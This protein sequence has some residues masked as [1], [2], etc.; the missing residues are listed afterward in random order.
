MI[1][2]CKYIIGLGLI[3]FITLTFFQG[4]AWAAEPSKV[5]ML[6]EI[7][8]HG[9]SVSIS[10]PPPS[11][12]IL[13]G[14]DL[15]DEY[16]DKPLFIMEKI[17]GVAVR[18]YGQ[19]AVASQFTMRGLR[20]GHNTGAAIFVDGVPL[21]E[22]TSHGDGYADLNLVIPED[23]DYIEVIKGPS[24]ALYG[25]FARAGVVN[26]ITKHRGNF[27]FYKFG[28]GNWGRKRFA[29]STGHEEG[30]RSTI[31][32][33]ELSRSEGATE[34][35]EWLKGNATGKFT[36]DFNDDIT[37]SIAMNFYATEWDHPEY[38]TEDQ[39]NAGDY[40]SAQSLGGG[41]RHRYGMSSNLTYNIVEDDFV[42]FMLYGYKCNLTRYR[43]RVTRVD[44]EY[45]DRDIWGGSLSYVRNSILADM[46]NTLTIGMDSQVELTHTLKA[47]NPSRIPTAREVITVNGESALNTYSFFFQDQL[48]PTES[49]KLTVGGRYDHMD[50]EIDDK[51][52]GQEK[53]MEDYNIF[54]PKASVEYIPVTGYTLFVTYGEG[55]RLPSGFDKFNYPELTEE[56]YAQYETGIKLSSIK[57]VNA[58]LT[59]FVLDVENEI[60]TDEA[61]GTKVNQ[62]KTRR[63]GVELEMDYSPTNNLQFYGNISYTDGKYKHYVNSG[64]DYSGSDIELISNWLYSFGAEWK[65][66]RGFFAG[67]DY[68]YVG[69]S[70]KEAYAVGYTGIRR[71]TMD[72]WV[73]DMQVGYRVKMYSLT[74]DVT[75]IFDKRYPSY[76]SASSYRTANPRGA[77]LT[78]SISY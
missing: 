35:S 24:S 47:Q 22:S 49:W 11:A 69:D 62:G 70:D 33:V 44:E 18:D 56:T 40:W 42:N 59:G 75:N 25:Q 31:F 55:F 74:L 50:G 46:N 32:G 3:L 17:P 7:V 68:R 4:S 72:F 52:A 28:S 14:E 16:F 21:N 27:S 1:N 51:L 71:K 9:K 54:S 57:N 23:I 66:P 58:S 76:E 77:F 48:S 39:W 34:N 5:L 13:K 29:M 20:L 45:H 41:K 12:L 30:K 2:R 36:Y 53:S 65:P 60:V 73:A 37:G 6:E 19:G 26:I 61:A 8:V 15:K 67:I 10:P 78:F 63:K 43:D 38:L 64:V